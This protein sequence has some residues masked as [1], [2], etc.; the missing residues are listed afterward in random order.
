MKKLLLI[1]SFISY[2]LTSLAQAPNNFNYQAVA[3]DASGNLLANQNVNFRISILQTS[4]V[5]IAVYVETHAKI[6]NAYG[7]ATLI[8]GGGTVITGNFST[9]NWGSNSYYLK[10]EMDATGGNN[11]S[12]MGTTQLLSVPYALYSNTS[13]NGGG[14]TYTSGSGININGN[15][16]SNTASD[17]TITLTGTGTTTVTGTYPNF[18][19]GSTDNS[20]NY[21]PGNGISINGN[22]ISNTAPN[23]VI[24]LSGSGA[25]S[26]SGSYPNFIISSTDNNTTLP[27][28]TTNQTLRHNGSTWVSNNLLFN[29][30]TRI[31]IGISNPAQQ[32]EITQNFRLP[33]STTTAGNIYKDANIFLHNKG[34][35]NVF[36]GVNSGNLALTGNNNTALGAYSL[37]SL[38]TGNYLTAVGAYALRNNSSGLQNTAVGYY[39]MFT[40]TTG[41]YNSAFGYRALNGNTTGY[42]N[43]AIGYQSLLNTNTG[44]S[45]TAIGYQ[46]LYANTTGNQ[47]TATGDYSLRSNTSGNENSSYGFYS[48]SLN[49]TG[50]NNSA[51]GSWSLKSNTT[52]YN[53]T[54]LGYSSLINN[55]G[56]YENTALGKDVLLSNTTGNRNTGIGAEALYTNQTASNNIAI[57]WR[58]LRNNISGTANTVIGNSAL[59]LNSGNYNTVVGFQAGQTNTAGSGNVFLGYRAG[60]NESGSNKLIINNSDSVVALIRGDFAAKNVGINTQTSHNSAVFEVSSS[61]KGVLLPRLSQEQIIS[62]SN[63]D[64]GLIAFNLTTKKFAFFN[65]NEWR[66]LSDEGCFPEPST[67]NAGSDLVVCNYPV[68]LNATTPQVGSG[69]WSILSGN[70]G[71]IADSLNPNSNFTGAQGVEYTLKWTVSTSCNSNSKSIKIIKPSSLTV[72]AGYSMFNICGNNVQLNGSSIPAGY[73]GTWSIISGNNG[74]FYDTTMTSVYYPGITNVLPAGYHNTIDT[75]Q[76]NNKSRIFFK[77][78]S[79]NTYQ[80][81]WT[82]ANSCASSFDDLTITFANSTIANAGNDTSIAGGMFLSV[83][84]HANTPLISETGTWLIENGES[85]SFSNIHDPNTTFYF[86]INKKYDLSWTISGPCKTTSSIIH[87]NTGAL[88]TAFDY[89]GQTYYVYPAGDNAD[90]IQWGGY[91]TQ[92]HADSLS[93]GMYNTNLIV[94]TLGTNNGVSYAAKVCYDLNYGGYNDWYLPSINE[95]KVIILNHAGEINGFVT[96][97]TY[98]S[99]TE[100]SDSSIRTY[101][102]ESYRADTYPFQII[103]SNYYNPNY[104]YIKNET[105]G[106]SKFKSGG[107]K[108]IIGG[109]TCWAC[110]NNPV[111]YQTVQYGNNRVRCIRKQ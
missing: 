101:L 42:E 22:I 12:V 30:D 45:N 10:T 57:G 14:T 76:L 88:N 104:S 106:F 86:A 71:I 80:L 78:Q 73:S 82:V 54:A 47:N 38:T 40:N 99:S 8:I 67:A 97:A 58:S 63:P 72:D 102:A 6:T 15:I 36:L 2:T 85:G 61:N 93:N 55:T 21:T 64:T 1:I 91:G 11:Y 77:G 43:T 25:T 66:T 3:R 24:T 44:Y 50:Y 19:I 4:A 16:I 17:Q 7:Q 20:I 111:T 28:G 62:I 109:E 103:Y 60:E 51:F 33:A 48:L 29:T 95:L 56:G 79:G 70:G 59:Q 9:I 13:G 5:G 75:V 18:T 35:D 65:G 96:G 26:V 98:L 23:Q 53:N 52:G 32:L 89:N 87:I 69:K 110:P 31:G 41:S 84:L 27:S 100:V 107:D 90:S 83:P 37:Y 105:S 68:Q 39:A 49:S 34:T 108:P 92:T 74:F 94:S 46:S 81:R